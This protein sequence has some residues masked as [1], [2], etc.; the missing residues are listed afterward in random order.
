MTEHD[1]GGRPEY[2]SADRGPTG[3]S[4]EHAGPTPAGGSGPPAADADP[5][6]AAD[7]DALRQL[8]RQSVRDIQPSTD[9][10]HHL[11]HAVPARRRR[12]QR[13]MVGAAVSVALF[14]GGTPVMLHAATGG[15]SA[16]QASESSADHGTG[17]PATDDGSGE[18]PG[19]HT[20]GGTPTEPGGHDPTAE[21]A[22]PSPGGEGSQEATAPQERDTLGVAAPR[23]SRD[24]LG[25]VITETEDADEQGRVHGYVRVANT[26]GETCRI[27]GADEFSLAPRGR[28]ESAGLQ[29]AGRAENDRPGR[30]PP[31]DLEQ[32]ELILRPGESYEVW[33]AWVPLRDGEN[34][35]CAADPVATP[36]PDTG[37]SGDAEGDPVSETLTDGDGSAVSGGSLTSGGSGSGGEGGSGDPGAGEPTGVVVT[38]VPAAGEP[39]AT[40]FTLP[41]A[42]AG[43][44]HRTGVLEA[45]AA[46]R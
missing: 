9:S 30:L 3:P 28:A 13:R 39:R 26:S 21:T 36:D 15:G 25:D 16:P 22:A 11:L 46:A 40:S 38:Y 8:L 31:A 44:L 34:G 24:Q 14:A 42:C 37:G 29:V 1:P 17:G 18:G 35:G 4:P 10:L 7:E 41:G 45:G 5:P 33:F 2:T 23:C 43:T 20:T 6:P 32:T 19:S 27:R 12:R